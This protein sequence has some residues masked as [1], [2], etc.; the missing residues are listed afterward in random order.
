MILKQLETSKT[1]IDKL[2]KLLSIKELYYKKT[3]K[4]EDT[5]DKLVLQKS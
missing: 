4:L 3:I 2:E 1:I 5:I